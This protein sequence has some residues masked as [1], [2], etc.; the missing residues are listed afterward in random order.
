[1][2]KPR[3]FY[4]LGSETGSVGADVKKKLGF[5]FVLILGAAISFYAGYT[6]KPSSPDG[7][8][9]AT[10]SNVAAQQDT[11]SANI[12]SPTQ[13]SDGATTTAPAAEHGTD[14][15][16]E[17]SKQDSQIKYPLP[18]DSVRKAK[19]RHISDGDSFDITFVD[20]KV[21]AEVR[22]LAI[23]APERGDCYANEAGELIK[24]LVDGKE[25]LV[26]ETEYDRYGRVLANVWTHDGSL[27]NVRLVGEGAAFARTTQ[28]EHFDLTLRAQEA[29]QS[30]GLGMWNSSTCMS[31]WS[32]KIEIDSVFADA[33][34]PDD[35]NLNGEY[36]VLANISEEPIDL[37][38]WYVRDEST[39][40]R[41]H[42]KNTM[43]EP[44]AFL[45][46]RS[47]CGTNTTE[48]QFWCAEVPVWNNR[49]DSAF[50]IDSDGLIA[51]SLSYQ[52]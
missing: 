20:N 49:G 14:A 13:T 9:A 8:T 41:H 5:A 3:L 1:M 31:E 47:G 12:S 39:T 19:V 28:S 26:E 2:S 23:N 38:G 42:F 24:D 40:N 15:H 37:H 18:P 7:Q 52:R 48:E 34:G 51:A 10:N 46:I 33:P 22:L 25:I 29:A 30:V 35:Q 6:Y 44:G 43:I 27:L 50:L 11:S 21:K 17:S 16:S 36:V 32:T 45:V 4:V